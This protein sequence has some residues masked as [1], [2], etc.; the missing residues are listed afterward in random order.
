MSDTSILLPYL[1]LKFNLE[2]PGLEECYKEGFE[3]AQ[4][5]L[6]EESNPYSKDSQEHAFWVEGWWDGFYGKSSPE[7]TLATEMIPA[8]EPQA[9]NDEEYHDNFVELF[10]KILEI[11]SVLV[12]SA[13]VGYQIY[14]LVA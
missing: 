7:L 13:F 9:T 14:E 3:C 5:G 4:Q 12:V 1:K 8:N 11:T 10:T 2:Y 6:E